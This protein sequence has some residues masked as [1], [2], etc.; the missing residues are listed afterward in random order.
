MSDPKT[1][2]RSDSGLMSRRA[3]LG[4]GAAFA[5]AAAVT[6][7]VLAAAGEPGQ[8]GTDVADLIVTNASVITMDRSQPT[9]TALA[10]ADG[11]L[12]VVGSNAAALAAQGPGT[13]IV[14]AGGATVMPGIHDGHTHP[15]EGGRL[16]TVASLNYAQLDIPGFVRRMAQL[17][18]RSADKE[19]DGWLDVSLWDASA[20]KKLPTRA[21]LDALDTR[22][23]ILVTS[24]D[25]HIALANSRALALAGIDK[26][27]RDPAGGEIGRSKKG[28][29]TGILLDSA[30]AL[31]ARLIPKPTAEDNA[32]ALAVGYK[33][34]AEAGITTCLHASADETELKALSILADRG[35]LPV[36]PHV[37]LLVEAEEAEDP[38]A[39]LSRV[40][41]LREK[42]G[43]PGIV[44]DNLKLFFDGVIEHPTQTAA[45]LAPYRV[46][47]GSKKNPKWTKG[48]DRGPTYW[49]PKV[50]RAAIR[51]AD[52]A[53]WQVHVHAIGDRATRTAL[54]AFEAARKVN[55]D[56]D[57][58]HTIT[59]LELVSRP[60]F[61][62]F[63]ELG[64]LASMQMQ[65]AER[66]SYTVDALEPYLGPKR[67]RHVYPSGSLKRAGA[68]LCGGSDWP[69]DP[70][71]PMRQIEMAVN[72]TADEIYAGYPKPL[73]RAQ[74]IGLPASLA[75]HTRNSAFQLHQETLSGRLR[76]GMAA[77]LVM[78]DRDIL[79]VPLKRISKAKPRLTM[80]S[81]RV[82]H[83]DGV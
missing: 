17:I 1:P 21:N 19:P 18:R 62:R 3:L 81:G 15:F 82:T 29:P 27:T 68:T 48:K 63:G 10:V 73:N 9:A 54:D 23:P 24:L 70:L 64:V 25:G 49:K 46:N 30:I 69:V 45:L 56:T 61:A 12:I 5:G 16:A 13:E 72:R 2:R 14:D 7:P 75:M 53:G 78:L 50:A 8:P 71:L 37:A 58:R 6:N 44:V 76:V 51:A 33:L 74:R 11:R 47:R 31:V 34:M 39:M 41:G 40:G 67:Y 59:H 52:A 79:G 20:M 77:D 28:V 60:D 55:G 38:A 57:N 35:P 32:D 4:R 83:R 22:R 80:T 43:R 42:Y 26:K 65:W 36:R 66:D